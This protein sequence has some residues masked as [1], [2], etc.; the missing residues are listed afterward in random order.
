MIKDIKEE[1]FNILIKAKTFKFI[2]NNNNISYKIECGIDES[3]CNIELFQKTTE[4]LIGYCDLWVD[5]VLTKYLSDTEISEIKINNCPKG[6]Y[7]II[8]IYCSN[9]KKIIL[10]FKNK[11]NIDFIIKKIIYWKNYHFCKKYDVNKNQIDNIIFLISNENS[12]VTYMKNDVDIVKGNN[13]YISINNAED[14]LNLRNNEIGYAIIDDFYDINKE[15]IDGINYNDKNIVLKFSN[16]KNIYVCNGYYND[17]INMV[18]NNLIDKKIGKVYKKG[19]KKW[20]N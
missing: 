6:K 12:Y 10:K 4:A 18:E 14:S 20:K 13:L 8:K 5:C 3:P 7:N 16:N 2:E 17:F 11:A 9:N 1:N 15:N 19:E